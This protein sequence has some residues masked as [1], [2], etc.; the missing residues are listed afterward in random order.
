MID[1]PFRKLLPSISGPMLALYRRVGL[2]PNQVTIIGC[3][4]AFVATGAVAMDW[5]WLAIVLWWI[6]RL[7]DGTDGVHARATN[8]VT[9]FGGYLDK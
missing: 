3:A 2:T 1:G 8:Q 4:F 7:F 6:G 9:P 5:A